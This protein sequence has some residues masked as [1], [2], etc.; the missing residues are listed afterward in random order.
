MVSISALSLTIRFA[1]E[2]WSK[3]IELTCPPST[4]IIP[5]LL[6]NIPFEYFA[7]FT[8]IFPPIIFTLPDYFL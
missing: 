2:L 4:F 6:S 3:L 1:L 8:I 7:S 5:E